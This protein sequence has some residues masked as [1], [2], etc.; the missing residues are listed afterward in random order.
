MPTILLARHGQASFGGA[1][2]DVLSKVGAAQADALAAE[3]ASRRL[4]VPEVLSGSL[5]RQRDTAAPAAAAVSGTIRIDHR[6]NEYDMD[7]ILGAHSNSS[8]RASQAQSPSRPISSR[9][10]Q[11]VLDRALLDWIEAGPESPASETWPAFASRVASALGDLALSLPSGTTGVVVTSGGV[12]AAVA[13]A[14]LGLAPAS[15]PTLN[16]VMINASLTKVIHG[17]RGSTLVAFNEHGHLERA[18]QSLV[19]YR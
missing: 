16:R 10:F 3:L 15:L 1:D 12:V 13:G 11:E 2:Y 9:D 4:S 5:R 6:W 17:R 19:T 18:G 7:D 8:L 14:L